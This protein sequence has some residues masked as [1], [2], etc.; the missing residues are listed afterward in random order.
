MTGRQE[1]PPEVVE[2]VARAIVGPWLP[3][4]DGCQFTLDQL[5]DVRWR[6]SSTQEQRMAHTQAIA[7]LRTLRAQGVLAGPGEVVVPREP[8]KAMMDAGLY[9]ASHDAEWADVYSMWKDMLAA[10]PRTGTEDSA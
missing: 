3:V 9:Q 2:A 1:F 8:T 10:A 6:R 5:R 7:T 4:P